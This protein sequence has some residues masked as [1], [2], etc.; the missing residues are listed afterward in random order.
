MNELEIATKWIKKHGYPVTL[1]ET[2]EFIKLF[3]SKEYGFKLL[4][5]YFMRP[6][7]E[8]EF[9]KLLDDYYLGLT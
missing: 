6:L 2:E 9:A 1:F 8:S 3:E 5:E 4:H 7:T